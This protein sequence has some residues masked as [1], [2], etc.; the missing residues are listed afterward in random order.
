M[1]KKVNKNMMMHNVYFWVKNGVSKQEKKDF[2]QGL[3]NLVSN[4]KE[5]NNAEIGIP[6]ATDDRDVVDLSFAYSLFTWF[7]SINDHKI[8]QE[9][10][11]HKKFIEDFS[12]LWEKVIVYDSDLV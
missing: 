9:H 3:K 8:Y 1:L 5:V 2:E 10:A 12:G 7:K 11:A 6:A 4:I